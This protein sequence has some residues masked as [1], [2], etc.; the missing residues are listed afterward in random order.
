MFPK[1]TS[2]VEYPGVAMH[3]G[4]RKDGRDLVREWTDRM[5]AE[6][7]FSSS[8]FSAHSYIF[9]ITFLYLGVQSNCCAVHVCLCAEKPLCMEQEATLITE[10]QQRGLLTG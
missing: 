4:T 9:T 6:V 5:K 8:S 3:S 7:H 10:P 2:D 1:N